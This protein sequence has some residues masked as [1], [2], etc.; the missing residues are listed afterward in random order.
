MAAVLAREEAQSL[1]CLIVFSFIFV[2]CVCISALLA[3]VV[4]DFGCTYGI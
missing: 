2:L 4:F 3:L 1:G